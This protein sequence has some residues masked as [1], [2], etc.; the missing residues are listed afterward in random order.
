MVEQKLK[1]VIRDALLDMLVPVVEQIKGGPGSGNFGHAGRPGQVGGSSPRANLLAYLEKV[2]DPRAKEAAKLCKKELAK[3][4]D[5][6]LEGLTSIEFADF[7]NNR[8]IPTRAAG[9]YTNFTHKVIL[10][11]G[12]K[13]LT[14]IGEIMLHEIGHHVWTLYTEEERLLWRKF[15]RRGHSDL[16]RQE[17]GELFNYI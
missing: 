8:L 12:Y 3:I 11:I 1:Q 16:E 5:K 2:D 10:N 15:L 6:D 14:G 4:P 9:A 7:N 13:T 17:G